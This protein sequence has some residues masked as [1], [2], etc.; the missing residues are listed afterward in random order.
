MRV[1]FLSAVLC[2][3]LQ[4]SASASATGVEVDP[5]KTGAECLTPR[6]SSRPHLRVTAWE[7][8]DRTDGVGEL[9]QKRE[10]L[11]LNGTGDFELTCNVVDVQDVLAGRG[12]VYLRLAALPGSRNWEGPD[13][14]VMPSSPE[15]VEV[16]DRPCRTLKIPYEGGDI[17]RRAALMAAQRELRPFVP[18]RDGLFLSNTWGDRNRDARLCEP[19][20]MKEIDA[21]AKLGVDV[22]QI[23]D[24]WQKGRSANSAALAK[25][26]NGRWGD[27]WSVD[28]FWDVDPV[29]FPNGL[30]PVVAA[31]RAKGMRFG[32]WFG[33]D[34]SDD[35]VNWKKDADFLLSLYRGLGI[36]Y[37]KL[38]SMKTQSPLALSRQSMLMDRLMDESG[39]RITIDLDVTAGRRPGYF[40]FPRI[41]PVF[42]ENR[43]IRRNERRLWWP[44][45]TLRNFWSLA[46]VVDPAR[47]RM[48]VLNPARMPELYLKDD[49]LAPMRWPRDAIFAISMFSSPLGWFE[50]QNLSPETIESWKPLIARWKQERDSVHEGYVY[51]V[52]A[53]PDGLSWTGFVSASRDGKEGTV[54][55]FRELDARVEYSFALSDYI[56]S[57]CGDAVVIGGHGEATL[58]DGVLHVM[59]SEK[60]GFIWVKILAGP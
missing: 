2:V 6:A 40:A 35:A 27:W 57:G 30:E 58:K 17:G 36:E 3:C 41:G 7:L 48:E 49:P 26:E 47:L 54:L 45:R 11:L 9:V 38:D 19:F 59:V 16:F 18:G 8:H 42:V 22:V 1:L 39:D 44:H 14:K 13:F 32:L 28:G 43:Y 55:L 4:L 51:P 50:I 46:H 52:G 15:G 33:P 12:T 5:A 10:W 34:S 53:A 56:P 29:R 31:A 24:G 60:L 21:A 25:G 23:D 37:F 20:M